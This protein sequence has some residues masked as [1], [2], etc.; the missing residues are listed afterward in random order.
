MAAP[1]SDGDG[2]TEMEAR[3]AMREAVVACE[4]AGIDPHLTLVEASSLHKSEHT[5]PT[6]AAQ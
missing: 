3:T 6:G 4:A 5:M 1:T 2:M